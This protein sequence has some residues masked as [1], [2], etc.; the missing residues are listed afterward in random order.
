MLD[1]ETLHVLII[2]DDDDYVFL[3]QDYLKLKFTS[4][5]FIFKVAKDPEEAIEIINSSPTF[6]LYIVD[7][8]LNYKNGIEIIIEIRSKNIDTPI[9]F[10]TGYGNEDVAVTA[11][12]VGA[13][14]Y[15]SKTKLTAE[16]LEHSVLH[17]MEVCRYHR[18][19]L[20]YE[21]QLKLKNEQLQKLNTFLEERVKEEIRKNQDKE[22]MMLLQNKHAVMGEMIGYIAHQW[23][24][25]INAL[26]LLIQALQDDFADGEV[27]SRYVDGLVQKAMHIINYMSSTIEDF[28]NFFIP[29]KQSCKCQVSEIIHKTVNLIRDSLRENSI[30]IHV[31]I[32]DDVSITCLPNQLCHVLLNILSNARDALVQNKTNDSYVKITVQKIDNH[33]QISIKDNAGGINQSILNRLFS[34]YVTTKKDGT[35]IGLYMSKLMIE[36]NMK[37]SITAENTL[38]GAEFK[39][40][41]P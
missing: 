7:Y 12:K 21:K 1:K 40:I 19:K 11:M 31:D 32:I 33:C 4:T 29:D 13:T 26:A 28:R 27:D 3:I 35:G 25:P 17:S 39:I 34:P 20:E 14:D 6:D 24:Q 36:N 38:E 18:Q 37:G 23:K 5:D 8:M 16:L 10:L 30:T 2:D 9:I 22:H 41:L 15:I